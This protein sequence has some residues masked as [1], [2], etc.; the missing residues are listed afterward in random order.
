MADWEWALPRALSNHV[1]SHYQ[2]A[3]HPGLLY[4]KFTPTGMQDRDK[5]NWLNEFRQI[6]LDRG[7]SAFEVCHNQRARWAA[8]VQAAGGRLYSSKTFSRLIVGL[9]GEHVL[10][11]AI[12]LDRNCGMPLIPGGAVKGIARA[13]ALIEVARQFPSEP[14]FLSVIVDDASDKKQSRLGMLDQWLSEPRSQDASENFEALQEIL[15][16]AIAADAVPWHDISLFQR[17]FGT[18]GDKGQ[19]G[20]ICFYDALYAGDA[21][22]RFIVDV[23]TPHFGNYYGDETGG[24]VAPSDDG[25]PVPVPYLVLE[26]AHEF[27][28][29]IAPRHF[30]YATAQ[31]A[32]DDMGVVQ[33][34]LEHGI[35]QLGVGAKTAQGYGMFGKLNNL[36]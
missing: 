29:G 20:S 16:M 26:A 35:R 6:V 5:S 31:Q 3:S 2:R 21:S 27:V 18:G 8:R 24:T 10:D 4:E 11:T 36:A 17:L 34:L 12:T 19:A 28:F 14:D 7:S 25:T 1:A 13:W 32:S 22:P 30:A 9:G 23:M 15:G 33:T